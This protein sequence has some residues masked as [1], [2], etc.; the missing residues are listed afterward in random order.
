M[1]WNFAVMFFF[2]LEKCIDTRGGEGGAAAGL[3]LKQEVKQVFYIKTTSPGHDP[4]NR[5]SS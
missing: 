1:W 4:S 5:K 2:L 3:S